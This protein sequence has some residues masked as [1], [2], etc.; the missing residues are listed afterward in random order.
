MEMDELKIQN[1][2]RIV[3]LYYISPQKQKCKI[4]M[5]D[6]LCKKKS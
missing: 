4:V 5:N 1:L 2:K 6:L 3:F